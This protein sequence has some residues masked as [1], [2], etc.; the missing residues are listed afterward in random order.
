MSKEETQFV[1]RPW[2]GWRDVAS[3]PN[4]RVKTLTIVQGQAISLQKHFYRDERWLVVEGCGIMTLGDEEFLVRPGD[5]VMIPRLTPHRIRAQFPN[6]VIVEV[7]TGDMLSEDDIMRLA[8]D[9]GR[10]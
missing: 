1:H 10:D 7:Q 2:G 8:D 3:G 9:Y 5:A 4:F 6:M